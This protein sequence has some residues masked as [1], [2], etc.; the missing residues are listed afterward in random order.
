MR[1]RVFE[2]FR[3]TWG[4]STEAESQP[5]GGVLLYAQSILC[6]AQHLRNVQTRRPEEATATTTP[7]HPP[8]NYHKIEESPLGRA[9]AR[10]RARRRSHHAIGISASSC[11]DSAAFILPA[12][13]HNRGSLPLRADLAVLYIYIF[14][15]LSRELYNSQAVA[16]V[17]GGAHRSSPQKKEAPDEV[18]RISLARKNA[19]YC[20]CCCCRQCGFV[21]RRGHNAGGACGGVC[22]LGK[23]LAGVIEVRRSSLFCHDVAIPLD[24]KGRML[25]SGRISV[26]LWSKVWV[27]LWF[28]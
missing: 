25:F 11:A 20:C 18:S 21:W 14:I 16:R 28:L 17:H 1:V 10:A 26:T 3:C 27:R 2:K 23:A 15:Y 6:H 5:D 22:T 9:L 8:T 12:T 4:G 19:R 13:R 7:P 24:D